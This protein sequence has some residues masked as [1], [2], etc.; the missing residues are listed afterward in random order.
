MDV[1]LPV[2]VL[3]LKVYRLQLR[4]RAAIEAGTP[5][6]PSKGATPTTWP[7]VINPPIPP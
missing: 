6:Y 7:N 2:D 3:A 4:L 1:N 5:L